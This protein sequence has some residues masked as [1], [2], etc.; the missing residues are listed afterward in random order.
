MT[1][2][3]VI[4]VGYLI[5]KQC[6]AKKF[7]LGTLKLQKL[8]WYC[9]ILYYFKYHEH[10][11]EERFRAWD[12]GVVLKTAWYERWKILREAIPE[13]FEINTSIEAIV[14]T[15]VDKKGDLESQELSDENHEQ[16]PWKITRDKGFDEA[17]PHK[18]IEEYAKEI[19]DKYLY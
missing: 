7:F 16:A 13:N 15:V 11:F 17:I 3:K 9:A 8:L 10:L 4:K 18:L 5:R 19:K 2:E 14:K 1:E 12:Y 6:E